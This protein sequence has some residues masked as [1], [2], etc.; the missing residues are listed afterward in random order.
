M[1]VENVGY[2]MIAPTGWANGTTPAFATAT[3]GSI[4]QSLVF[5]S[6]PGDPVYVAFDQPAGWNSDAW[7]SDASGG[8]WTC[9]VPGIY[10]MNISQSLTV[11]NAAD[12]VNPVV[13]VVMNMIDD[14][15]ADVNQAVSNSMTVPITT[16]PINVQTSVSGIVVAAVGTRMTLTIVSPSAGITIDS[17]A[18]LPY[19]VAFSYNLIAQGPYAEV[20]VL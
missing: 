10:L 1:S 11:F 5:T 14:N 3:C 2:G 9:A 4:F 8:T 16:A 15:Y 7:V 17:E 12:I 18:Y 20:S 13:N 6:T 19:N